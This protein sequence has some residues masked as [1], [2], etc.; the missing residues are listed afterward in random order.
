MSDNRKDSSIS[1]R[2]FLKRTLAVAAGLGGAS[3]LAACGAAPT[4]TPAPPAAAATQ[5]PAAPTTAPAAAAPTKPPAAPAPT[6]APAA[7]PTKPPAAGATGGTMT[8]GYGQKTSYSHFMHFRNYAGG[9]TVY[10]RTFANAKLVQIAE[11]D[12]SFYGDLAEKYELAPDGKSITFSLRKGLKWSDGEPLT[13]KDVEFS[14]LMAGK[15]LG[16]DRPTALLSNFVT[17]VTEYVAE[18]ADKIEGM[19]VVDDNTIKF[20]LIKPPYIDLLLGAFNNTC[21]GPV[22]S[23]SQYLPKDKSK[24]IL[25]SEWATTA[26]HIGMGPFKVVEYVPDQ[27][28]VYEPN[29]NYHFGKPKLGKLV[30]RSFQDR[31]TLA[32][33]LEKKEIDVGWIPDSEYTRMSKLDFL[34]WRTPPATLFNGTT[35]N[36]RRPYLADKRVRQALLYAIDRDAVI[37]TIYAGI[38]QKIDTPFQMPRIGESPN[39][40]RYNYDPNKAKQLLKDAGWDG[41]TKLRWL[42][43]AVPADTSLNDALKGY[44]SAVGIETEWQIQPYEVAI[45]PKYDFD[46]L[47]SAWPLGHPTELN[48]YLDPRKQGSYNTGYDDKTYQDLLDKSTANI[49]DD[50][51]KKLIYQM[52]EM[53]ADQALFIMI[54]R[55]PNAWGIAKRVHNILPVY[56][57]TGFTDWG[58]PQNWT[59]DA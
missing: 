11:K 25:Q 30:Y 50:E 10:S 49:T 18:K 38:S 58:G 45:A 57:A 14:F 41:K 53:V 54:N 55:T 27:Y 42:Y 36:T 6:T 32:A 31:T 48:I 13:A 17:G 12:K 1:R 16:G 3:L 35:I 15:D 8:V 21:I 4:A 39:L 9:E 2:S 44:W 19:K 24:D 37:K 7:A 26:K 56:M 40:T 43:P 20:D 51:M 28:I 23:L 29:P 22:H 46:I 5:P 47:W 52:Q 33:A 34:D 59:A